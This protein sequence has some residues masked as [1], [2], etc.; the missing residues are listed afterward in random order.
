MNVLGRVENGVVVLEGPAMLPEGAQVVVL[1]PVAG[2]RIH[3]SAVRKPA[4]LPLVKTGRPSSVRLTNERIAG[5]LEAEDI[6]AMKGQ[7][8]A[9]S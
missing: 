1:Y 2:P 4:Q 8:D 6:E 9:S 3:V 7:W 5:I